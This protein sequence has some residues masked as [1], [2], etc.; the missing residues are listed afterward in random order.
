MGRIPRSFLLYNGCYAHVEA[1]NS[2]I[3]GYDPA[4]LPE[5]IDLVDG[6]DFERGFAVGG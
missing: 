3:T 2:L 5:D 4:G 1:R 6:I